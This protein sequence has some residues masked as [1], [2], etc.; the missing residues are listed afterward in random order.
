MMLPACINFLNL[1]NLFFLTF[2]IH[3]FGI[4]KLPK[5]YDELNKISFSGEV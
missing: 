5:V 3:L 2:N 4:V 1:N